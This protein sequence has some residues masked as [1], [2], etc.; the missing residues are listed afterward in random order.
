MSHSKPPVSEKEMTEEEKSAYE[1]ITEFIAALEDA[2]EK[3][4]A[5]TI[6]GITLQM[7]EQD[8]MYL[9]APPHPDLRWLTARVVCE[10]IE[11]SARHTLQLVVNKLEEKEG[12]GAEE[13]PAS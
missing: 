10:R 5:L 2:S 12:A 8:V 13:P 9:V 7:D 11:Q 6:P 3:G 4:Q 1:A